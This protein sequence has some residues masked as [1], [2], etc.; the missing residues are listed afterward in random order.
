MPVR[1]QEMENNQAMST[2][3]QPIT[4]V[5]LNRRIGNAITT[6]PGLNNVWI[7]AET[8]DVRVSGGHC[9]MELIQK[10]DAGAPQAKIRAAIWAS[11]YSRLAAR[12]AEATGTRFASDMK[13]MVCVTASFHN[14]YGLCL[15]VNDINPEYTVG[16]LV[17][18]RNEIIRRLQAEGVFDLNR[19]LE[20]PRLPQKI[21]VISARGAA[22]Y[23]DFVKHLYSNPLNLRFSHRLFEAAL[24]GERAPRSIIAAL[25]AIITCGEDFDCVVIIRGGG[26]VS[27]LASFDDYELANNVAQFPLPII[28]GIG[29][30]R[31]ITVLDYV[32]NARVKTPTAAA[33]LIIGR[34]TAEYERLLSLGRAILTAVNER[35]SGEQRRLEYYRGQIPSLART[36][37]I[38]ARA[39]L[40]EKPEE[41]LKGLTDNAISRRR[42]R[43]DAIGELLIALAPEATLRR[44]YSI[45]RVNGH[46]VTDSSTL[47][48]GD[49]ITTTFATGELVESTVN[50]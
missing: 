22:G 28:V 16:D 40:G 43:L 50:H 1:R 29:H 36:V 3:Q 11:T 31:D 14:V 19:N 48:P 18:K 41:I 26:A 37:L 4:L 44:G 10:N 32:A 33:E 30:E 35:V 15:I 2:I 9:Y 27:D 20:F 8:S 13:V 25:E 46:A 5:E 38:R 34:V 17:R 47:H 21:A 24:Q 23:G 39:R 45:T 42:Q 49:I 12:F 7:T 6:T